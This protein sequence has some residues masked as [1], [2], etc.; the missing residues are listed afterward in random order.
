MSDLTLTE[1]P[2]PRGWEKPPALSQAVIL[3]VLSLVC[4]STTC[5]GFHAWQLSRGTKER[6]G[7]PAMEAQGG[8]RAPR[9]RGGQWGHPPTGA[10]G[11]GTGV[12]GQDEAPS[13]TPGSGRRGHTRPRP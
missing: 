5:R 11:K 8:S 9:Q 2:T 7:R 13:P 3:G 10:G 6:S 12:G 1:N 4:A